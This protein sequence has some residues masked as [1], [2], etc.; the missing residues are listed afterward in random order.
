MN[1]LFEGQFKLIPTGGTMKAVNN[2][3]NDNGR[4]VVTDADSAI[5]IVAVG[6]NYSL[7]SSIFLENNSYKKLR[8]TASPHQK[9][10]SIIKAASGKNY[11]ALL[12]AHKKDYTAFFSR[13]SVDLDAPPSP[14]PTD[15]LLKNYKEGILTITSRNYIFSTA[16]TCSFALRGPAHCRLICKASGAS[17]MLVHGPVV[18]GTT[19]TYK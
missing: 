14:L 17:T 2:G 15:L 4:I 13:V 11:Q 19:S 12:A 5:I 7:D 1:L 10:S 18:T 6:T 9:V 3:D 8:D 16:V